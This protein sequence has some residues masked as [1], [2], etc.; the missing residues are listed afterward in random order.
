MQRDSWDDQIIVE[1]VYKDIE[2]RIIAS[3]PTIDRVLKRLFSIRGKGVRP[4]ITA[5]VGKMV[6][7]SWD[8]LR[9]PAMVV[10]AVHISS[11]IHDDV[12]DESDMRRGETTIHV[13]YSEKAS[14]LIGDLI[15]IKALN[16]ARTI[17]E[18][19]AVDVIHHAVERMLEGEMCEE[20][21][22]DIIDEDAYLNII[23]NKTASLF[24]AAGEL[25]VIVSGGTG[26]QRSMARELG[27]SIG[28]AFQIIDD[29]LDI[30]G[31]ADVMGKPRFADVMSVRFTLP[32]IHSL[33]RFGGD[34]IKKN[35]ADREA[36]VSEIADLIIENGGIDYAF[37]KARQ[38]S[39]KARQ[40]VRSLDS[41]QCG[42][43]F[44]RFFDLLMT[45]AS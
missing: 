2:T 45:R 32:V 44:E 25:G 17:G 43:E 4:V 26:E 35:F 6:G 37:D 7:G 11:L 27:E 13:R 36:A 9:T 20:L 5:L 33:G 38:Y 3:D 1:D 21:T 31:D 41:G 18:P 19:A 23:G 42:P 28:M 22:D 8:I 29:T 14:V 10:E 30:I 40:I 39:E 16:I 24:A 15:F 12:V 34:E